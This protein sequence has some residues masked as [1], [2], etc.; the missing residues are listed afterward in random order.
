ML[1]SIP[2]SNNNYQ[3]MTS[4]TRHPPWGLTPIQV[5]FY[6]SFAAFVV[7]KVVTSDGDWLKH[8]FVH[9]PPFQSLPCYGSTWSCEL[10]II[11]TY[12]IHRSLEDLKLYIIHT[13]TLQ[14]F[15][16]FAHSKF[17][18]SVSKTSM[19]GEKNGRKIFG[20]FNFPPFFF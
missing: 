4:P 20:I 2:K 15:S 13:H 6:L 10:W 12:H 19:P 14:S 7:A 18:N 17:V 1:S 11:I 3:I 16:S 9:F 8:C 5:L